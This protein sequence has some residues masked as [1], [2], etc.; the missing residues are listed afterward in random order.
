MNPLLHFREL[1]LQYVT[2]MYAKIESER[3]RFIRLNQPKLRVENYIHLRDDV[4]RGGN[5]HDVGQLTILPSSFTGGP[6]YMHEKSIDAL[7]YLRHFGRP[8]FFITFTANPKWPEIQREL[9]G[10][11]TANHRHDMIARVFRQKLL[12]MMY[13]IKQDKIFGEVVA[14]MYSIEWQKRGLVH[15]HILLWLKTKIHPVDID[16][17]I[18]AEI[19]DETKDPY[20][21]EIIK[22]T[23]CHGP[24]GPW[25]PNSVC[26]KENK[27]TKSYPKPFLHETQQNE[28]GYPS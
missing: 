2:D 26:M 12:K 14:H 3:L 6:R 4:T 5:L 21:F 1:Y 15:A 19:P 13:I 17:V 27:C 8:T 24:C 9:K 28:D 23:M 11:Q 18:C 22:R 16:K 7:V 10:S 25:N 20:L